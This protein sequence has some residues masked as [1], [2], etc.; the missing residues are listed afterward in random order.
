[1]ARLEHAG[2]QPQPEADRLALARRVA[3]DL[4]G[5]PPSVA[6]AD[7]FVRDARP[8]AYE[9]FVDA[10]LAKPAFGEHWARLWL[11][12]ARYADSKGY[13]DDQPRSI[14]RYRDWVTRTPSTATCRSI[15]SR[16]NSSRA[17]CCPTRPRTN[18]SR[19]G[20]HRNTM[21]NTEGGTDDEEFRSVAVVDRVNTTFAV[22]M[23]T[24]M[25]VRSANTHKYDP[26]SQKEYFQVYALLNQTADADRNDE[27]PVLEFFTA[28]QQQRR[29]GWEQEIAALHTQL[30]ALKPKQALAAQRWADQFAASIAWQHPLPVQATTATGAA[31]VIAPNGDVALPDTKGKVVLKVDYPGVGFRSHP[32]APPRDAAGGGRVASSRGFAWA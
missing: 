3:L 24:S 19:L 11:D 27:A 10:Q 29:L 30:D 23:G 7:A 6:E 26:I 25:A 17:T 28:D 8:D 21:N 14:W 9:R 18:S 31:P 16:L 15:S 5:L 20:F 22:W 12:L 1:L 13:A 32:C 2:L 4:T